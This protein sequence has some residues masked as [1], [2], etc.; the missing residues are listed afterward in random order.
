MSSPPRLTDEQKPLHWRH[1]DHDGVS[2]YQPYDCLRIRLFRHRSKKTSKLR[3]TGLCVGNS[4][5]PVNSPHKGPVSRKMFPFDDVIM[6]IGK[7]HHDLP[8]QLVW[9]RL[10]LIAL[11]AP[12]HYLNQCWYNVNC[13]LGSK[14]QGDW[15]NDMAIFAQENEF[16]YVLS[17]AVTILSR[18]QYVKNITLSA[19]SPGLFTKY[20]SSIWIIQIWI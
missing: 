19:V 15:N 4:P 6:H 13:T 18:P 7:V 5:G 20:Y 12:T 11:L 2:N 16:E 17:R 3:V 14:F 1:N 10:D 8:R 9:N